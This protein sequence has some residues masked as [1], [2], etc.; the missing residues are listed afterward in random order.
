MIEINRT[1]QQ[2][3]SD[4]IMHVE[5]MLDPE[6]VYGLQSRGWKSP[7]APSE[8]SHNSSDH[9]KSVDEQG[10]VD[11]RKNKYDWFKLNAAEIL[12]KVHKR[13]AGLEVL[14][15]TAQSTSSSVSII[16]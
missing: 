14:K 11:G 10:R 13:I 12:A 6:G 7:A 15:R 1:Q 4:F 2:V 3:L 16:L 5:Q 9:S 8:A